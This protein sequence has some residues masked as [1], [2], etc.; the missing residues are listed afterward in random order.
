VA[1]ATAGFFL[2]SIENQAL[3]DDRLQSAADL[4]DI[5]A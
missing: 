3:G 5:C 4:L 1:E 2:E